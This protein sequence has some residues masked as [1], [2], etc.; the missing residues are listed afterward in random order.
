MEVVLSTCRHTMFMNIEAE[1][2][3]GKR[4]SC[5]TN[6]SH[7]TGCNF[8]PPDNQRTVFLTPLLSVTQKSQP[9]NGPWR[10]FCLH[11]ISATHKLWW[12]VFSTHV[13]VLTSEFEVSRVPY[14]RNDV[15]P[16]KTALVFRQSAIIIMM[17]RQ[18]YWWWSEPKISSAYPSWKWF[19]FALIKPLKRDNMQFAWHAKYSMILS[20]FV[21][22]PFSIGTFVGMQHETWK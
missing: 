13:V 22:S 11:P 4:R 19:N 7:S 17:A 14:L 15:T 10:N 2:G 9:C 12:V 5:K 3:F 18:R 8:Q 6:H 1:P 20:V 16:S 21:F